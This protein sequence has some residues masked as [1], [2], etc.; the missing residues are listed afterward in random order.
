MDTSLLC[1]VEFQWDGFNS[2]RTFER[3]AETCVH[4]ECSQMHH[5]VVFP[6][7]QVLHVHCTE[8]VKFQVYENDFITTHFFK[9]RGC[10]FSTSANGFCGCNAMAMH[11]DL[12]MW[13]L[14]FK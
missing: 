13:Q 4:V 5:F 12:V 7:V 8:I 11:K 6:L 2:L 14:K 9:R 1:S 10:G 3:T